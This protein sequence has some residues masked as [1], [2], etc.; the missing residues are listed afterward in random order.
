MLTA[1]KDSIQTLLSNMSKKQQQRNNSNG[2]KDD[3]SNMME[4]IVKIIQEAAS[5]NIPKV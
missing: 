5:K 4:G 3:V 1:W 2:V